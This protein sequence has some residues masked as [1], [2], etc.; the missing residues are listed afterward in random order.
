M[1]AMT[2]LGL[3]ALLTPWLVTSMSAQTPPPDPQ[4]AKLD[5]FVGVWTLA[6]EQKASAL[7]TRAGKFE[8]T[9]TCRKFDGGYHVV[10]DLVGTAAGEPFHEI[11]TFGYDAE[12]KRFTWF[13]IDNTGTNGLAYGN[14]QGNTWTFV[15][16]TTSGGT[17][18]R[19][20][21]RITQQSATSNLTLWD[22]AIGDGAWQLIGRFVGTK[23]GPCCPVATGAAADEAAIRLAN[24]RYIELHPKGALDELIAMYADDAVLLPPGEPPVQG[25]AAI[26][27]YWTQ[28]FDAF[29]VVDATSVI[30]EVIVS[31]DI[32]YSRGHFIETA[33]S[34]DGKTTAT[35]RGKFS[36]IW[37]R[38]AAGG[39]R[40][41][42]DM[43]N[44]DP[45]R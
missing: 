26:R 7:G 20:R 2:R 21:M 3:A 16:D 35:E 37:R 24:Q 36:G 10:C 22:F 4:L 15:W 44:L 12:S 34:R 41:G 38:N 14:L 40:I 28:F 11:A 43:W 17:R 27:A 18:L 31:G 6:G 45:P 13:D 33:R 9:E 8:G 1:T 19:T 32:A 39:W 30:D 23:A 42:R 5:A 25:I 29:I